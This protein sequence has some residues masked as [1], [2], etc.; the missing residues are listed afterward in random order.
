MKELTASHTGVV[1]PADRRAGTED[2][3]NRS[4]QRRPRLSGVSE[5]SPEMEAGHWRKRGWA[6]HRGTEPLMVMKGLKG[7]EAVGLGIPQNLGR[8]LR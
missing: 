4:V 6:G 5:I 7:R 8:E 2:Q 1:V 3:I